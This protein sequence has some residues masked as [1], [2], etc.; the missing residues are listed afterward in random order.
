MAEYK[1][2]QQ[3]LRLYNVRTITSLEQINDISENVLNSSYAVFAYDNDRTKRYVSHKVKFSDI[4]DEAFKRSW[5]YID[6]LRDELEYFL[7]N[8]DLKFNETYL[9]IVKKPIDNGFHDWH[10]QRLSYFFTI[11]P[12]ISELIE[13]PNSYIVS[14]IPEHTV[15]G[16]II[17]G[18]YSYLHSSYLTPGLISYT[19]LQDYIDN[20]LERLMG[21]PMTKEQQDQAINSLQ[22]FVNWFTN[23][24]YTDEEYGNLQRLIDTMDRKDENVRL[25]SY[26]YTDLARELSYAY[27][28]S[29]RDSINNTLNGLNFTY[30]CEE[31]RFLTGIKQVN[32]K[33]VEVTDNEGGSNIEVDQNNNTIN[34][35]GTQYTLSMTNGKLGLYPYTAIAIT[36]HSP[37]TTR[38][39]EIDS[40]ASQ[41][42]RTFKITANKNISSYT[43]SGSGNVTTSGTITQIIV[44]QD[45][46]NS[47]T[48]KVTIS[49]GQSSVTSSNMT[50]NFTSK[51]YFLGYSSDPNLTFTA[52]NNGTNILSTSNYHNL[53][54]SLSTSD[55]FGKGFTGDGYWYMIWPTTVSIGNIYFGSG[56]GKAPAP[57]GWHEHVQN[58][59]EGDPATN[60][61]HIKVNQY[62][63]TVQYHVYRSDNSFS[64]TMNIQF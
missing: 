27:T 5:T 45:G 36:T 64:G 33:I 25:L 48:R 32:G 16:V 51:R 46:N 57:G 10:N 63:T 30:S 61:N 53:K 24:T 31:H 4:M 56:T 58:W 38:N 49:D 8:L 41:A 55:I 9:N 18:E 35:N 39:V 50:L 1:E 40:S 44:T 59:Q 12:I 29:E 34:V 7:H 42:E 11:N 54:D 52:S 13:E 26:A 19:V 28:A 6:V 3:D 43:W 22:E 47:I 21:V 62:S 23:Y 60:S 20:T 37:N 2:R 15:D 17:P 14:Y